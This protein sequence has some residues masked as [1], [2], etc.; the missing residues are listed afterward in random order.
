MN[1]VREQLPL[2]KL[3]L[4]A[5]IAVIG[6]LAGCATPTKMPLAGDADSIGPGAQAIFLMTA[7]LRNDYHP[8]HQPQ[9]LV[10]N[11]EKP[12]AKEKADRFN[13]TMDDKARSFGPG[14]QVGYRYLFRMQL[15]AGD[16]IIRGFT[17]ISRKFPT[18][19]VYFAPLHADL[20]VPATGVYYL[21]H[22]T[23]TIRERK[24][25]EF[26]AGPPIP[27]IDQAVA[28]FSGGT[29]DIEVSDQ[30]DTDL[31]EFLEKFPAL[32]TVTIQK[33][34]LAPFD[35]AKAQKFWQDH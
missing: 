34:I 19:G 7:N 3:C 27:L 28:G 6:L 22:I 8:S 16:Y 24:G 33:A 12:D 23:A 5:S 35:R 9:V 17:G 13:F 18:Q 2:K 15:P 4:L 11:V 20:K 30:S 25:D 10:V 14:S 21:G 29:F 26:R 1:L 32:R 31:K